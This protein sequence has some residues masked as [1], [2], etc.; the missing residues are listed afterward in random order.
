M[1]RF[2]RRELIAAS[3]L[4]LLWVSPAQ[5]QTYPDRPVRVVLPYTAG[6]V[7]DQIMRLLAPTMEERLGQ[8]L[9]IEAKPGAAGNIGT[10]DVAKAEPD[11]YTILVAA[12]NN[13]VIN[14]FTMKMPIDPL[15]ALTPV[16][17]SRT[18]RSF[19]FPIRRCR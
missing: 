5:T 3:A 9:V 12:T 2:D 8:R 15:T 1:L 11:G 6:G 7:S 10:L 18:C 17:N 16:A 14:Q 19:C 13:Y 4:T